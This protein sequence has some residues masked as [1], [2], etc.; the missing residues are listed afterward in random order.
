MK[1]F[2]GRLLYQSCKFGVW[3]ELII[4]GFVISGLGL[5]IGKAGE[6]LNN[7]LPE[8]GE[9]WNYFSTVDNYL[10]I[11]G[12]KY[13][14]TMVII[15]LILCIITKIVGIRLIRSERLSALVRDMLYTTVDVIPKDDINKRNKASNIVNQ[16]ANKAVKK[17]FAL[18]IGK[19]E[20]IVFVYMPKQEQVKKILE[21]YLDDVANDI[22][23][24]IGFSSGNW[25]DVSGMFLPNYKVMRFVA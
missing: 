21:G 9:Y 18:W 5:L 8:F 1:P 11:L 14:I 4:I 2:V 23:R 25:E 20:V 7:Q 10:C 13:V 17:S 12:F 24:F 6:F 3:I 19:K 16:L 15:Y 22:S